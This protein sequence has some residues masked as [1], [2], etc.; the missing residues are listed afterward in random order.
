M[1]SRTVLAW[2][3]A[4]VVL[5]GVGLYVAT[6]SFHTE[7]PQVLRS[8]YCTAQTGS[9][10]VTLDLDQMAN[11]AT[12]A[13][14]GIRKGVPNRAVEIALATSLQESKLQNLTGGD[15]DSIGLFQQRPSQGWGSAKQ[16]GDPR[17]A[18]ARFYGALVHV[19]GWQ[20][21]SVTKA[22]QSVQRSA[23]PDAYAKWT[24]EAATLSTA[25]LGDASHAVDCYVGSTPAARGTA[26]IGALTTSLRDDWGSLL[27]TL[28]TG[29]PNT[30]S[31]G[32][33]GSQSGWQY[34]HWLV[35][36]ARDDGIML[37]RFGNQQWTAKAGSWGSV[38][39]L[40]APAAGETVVAQVFANG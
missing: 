5:I 6:H 12:I 35:A 39:N 16:I 24:T 40:L 37:V 9:G 17:Y 15:R 2:L 32:V 10:V 33:D 1:R 18:A 30:I 19:K 29:A 7:L 38:N 34:A 20:S 13:A 4:I 23:H 22:A 8:E 25:L 26:A 27:D 28:P 31:L 36:H 3:T 21:M 11:A 14:V